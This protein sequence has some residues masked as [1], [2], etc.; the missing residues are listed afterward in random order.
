MPWM[1][2]RQNVMF[3]VRS[4]HRAA[5]RAEVA[6]RAAEALALVGLRDAADRR[7]AHLSGGMKQRVGIAHALSVEPAI[8]LL[9][10]RS[11]RSTR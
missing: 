9:A 5:P 1:T 7:P 11:A 10:S 3:A 2:A 6:R 8:L 4:R